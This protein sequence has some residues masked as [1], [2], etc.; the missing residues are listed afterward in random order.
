MSAR[1]GV[2]LAAEMHWALM[3]EIEALEE[4]L[5]DAR[6][7]ADCDDRLAVLTT[8]LGEALRMRRRALRGN[9][10]AV[11]QADAVRRPNRG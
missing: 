11:A 2:Q 3:V 6:R 9:R 8:E 7:H 10:R 5:L 4:L 1:E